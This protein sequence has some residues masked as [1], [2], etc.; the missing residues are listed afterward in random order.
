MLLSKATCFSIFMEFMSNCLYA[1]SLG[2]VFLSLQ[3]LAIRSKWCR[4]RLDTLS[5]K[6]KQ[7]EGEIGM[8]VKSARF[9]DIHSNEFFQNA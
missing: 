8:S 9:W 1:C 7:R 2:M 5:I 6:P 4:S 3:V